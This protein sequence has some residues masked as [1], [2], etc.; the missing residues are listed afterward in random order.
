MNSATQLPLEIDA[1]IFDHDG[2]L[3]DSEPVHHKYWA[4]TLA[5]YGVDLSRD[6]YQR[7]LSGRPTIRSAHWLVDTH[8]LEVAAQHICD[9]KISA[10]RE[11]L[12]AHAFPIMP[13]ADAL[14]R[15]LA[16]QPVTLAVASGASRYE[17]ER[18]LSVHALSPYFKA[19]STKDDVVNNKPAPDVY[20]N[21]ADA[22]G[23]RPEHCLAI[24]DSDSGQLAA[25]AAGMPC[26]RLKSHTTLAPDPRVFTIEH[27]GLAQAWIN[28]HVK[29]SGKAV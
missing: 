17:V 8:Q 3:V 14:V 26:L 10:L 28:S 27:V 22:I 15:W 4:A 5:P 25:Q 11:H 1:V 19:V 13:G 23:A 21:A 20:L 12:E 18:S 16:T 29:W 24:E 6:D 7:Q 9:S 2:T